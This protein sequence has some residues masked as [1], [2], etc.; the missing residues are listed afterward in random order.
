M[1]HDTYKK[2]EEEGQYSSKGQQTKDAYA[3]PDV[4]KD[5][6]RVR[7][8]RLELQIRWP[9]CHRV[10]SNQVVM[11][12]RRKTGCIVA[13]MTE[14]VIHTIAKP[15]AIMNH[16]QRTLPEIETLRRCAHAM[17]IDMIIKNKTND[18]SMKEKNRN[19]YYK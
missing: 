2:P 9:A 17:Y 4:E 7:Q 18:A 8:K 14:P 12:M 11:Q 5:I 16:I 10:F 13:I 15:G 3:H 19:A 1:P 6:M